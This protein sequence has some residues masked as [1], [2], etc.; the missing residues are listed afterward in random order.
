MVVSASSC[1]S[2]LSRF[3]DYLVQ[4]VSSGSLPSNDN[5]PGPSESISPSPDPS[6]TTTQKGS[7]KPKVP[8]VAGTTVGG[9]CLLAVLLGLLFWI[10]RRRRSKKARR[11]RINLAGPEGVFSPNVSHDEVVLIGYGSKAAESSFLRPNPVTARSDPSTAPLQMSWAGSTSDDY[12]SD[13]YTQRGTLYTVSDNIPSASSSSSA[14]PLTGIAHR[15][16][17]ASLPKGARSPLNASAPPLVQ[18][19]DGGVRLQG[20]EERDE[21]PN[22]L[23]PVYRASYHT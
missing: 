21:L 3:Q 20:A 14:R 7:S 1:A 2:L 16:A 5:I 8:L 18:Y 4:T 10:R 6:P 17:V 9:V 13:V 19:E 12:T 11:P 15:D 23:P 22:E